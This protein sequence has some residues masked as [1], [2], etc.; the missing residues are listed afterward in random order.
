VEHVNYVDKIL[1]KRE[2]VLKRVKELKELIPLEVE[3]LTLL[4]IDY[5]N[6]VLE[7]NENDYCNDKSNVEL[8]HKIM[9][10]DRM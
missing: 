7:G 4:E 2:Q 9:E 5:T 3:S 6:D 10:T 8:E 1:S